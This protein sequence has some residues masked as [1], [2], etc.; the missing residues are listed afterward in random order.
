MSVSERKEAMSLSKER[1]IKMKKKKKS[2]KILYFEIFEVHANCVESSLQ[3]FINSSNYSLA[4]VFE[5]RHTHI[6]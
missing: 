6:I 3:L 2:P 4:W 5:Q 1:N